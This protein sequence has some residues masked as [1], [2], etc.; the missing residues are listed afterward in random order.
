MATNNLYSEQSEKSLLGLIIHDNSLMTKIAGAIE[1][2]DFYIPEH[3]I[4]FKAIQ[5]AFDHSSSADTPFLLEELSRISP[6]SKEDWLTY[7][8]QLTLDKGLESNIEKYIELIKEKKQARDLKETLASSVE[9]VNK[10]GDSVTNLI[11]HVESKIQD[12]TRQKDLKDFENMDTLTNEFLIK[13]KKI[14]EEGIQ[15]GIKTGIAPLDKAIGGFQAGQFVV[16]AA[17]PS[18]GKTAFSLEIA[19]NVA[20]TGRKVGFF[21]LEMPADQIILRLLASDSSINSRMM[22]QPNKPLNQN[23]KTRLEVSQERIKKM[24]MRIDDSASLKIGELAWKARKAKE[25]DGLDMIII[26]Y[27][28]LIDSDSNNDTSRQQMISDISRQLKAIARELEIPVIALSQL[29]RRVEGRDNKRPMMSDIRESGAI[30]QDADIIMFLYREDYYKQAEE[31]AS[32]SHSDL[33][34]IIGKNRNGQTGSVKLGLDLDHG[35]VTTLQNTEMP[36]AH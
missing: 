3:Q 1:S 29:S 12:I 34:V 20:M 14:E 35:K 27:L 18:M 23:Q 15:S 5:N 17:R 4:L 25:S 19:K 32:Q 9:L 30:E 10:G 7:F 22:F 16:V 28:Q 11:G 36:K 2:V 24:H 31:R 21:S 26:D 8:A 33:E 6:K 13:M